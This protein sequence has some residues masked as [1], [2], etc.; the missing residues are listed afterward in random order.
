MKR[1]FIYTLGQN[2]HTK[3]PV[4]NYGVC[5]SAG[6]GSMCVCGGGGRGQVGSRGG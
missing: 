1:S 4:L 2:Y 5:V 6:G 3:W